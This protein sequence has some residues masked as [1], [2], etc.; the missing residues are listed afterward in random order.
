MENEFYDLFLNEVYFGKTEEIL[1]IENQLRVIRK[2]FIGTKFDASK[3]NEIIKLNRMIEDTFGF[4]IFSLNIELDPVPSASTLPV[5]YNFNVTMNKNNYSIEP[6][7]YKFK[8]E[9]DYRCIVTMS[10]G[11]IFN[12]YFTTEE[13]MACLLHELGM[14]FYSCMSEDNAI[15]TSI[16]TA[17]TIAN[18]ISNIVLDILDDREL[19]SY[20]ADMVGDF[21]FDKASKDLYKMHPDYIQKARMNPDFAR[22]IDNN[23]NKVA[24]G[25]A[26]ATYYGGLTADAMARVTKYI[27]DSPLYKRY[28]EGMQKNVLNHRP[29][30]KV[31][32]NFW[33]Y[34]AMVGKKLI[35]PAYDFVKN[36]ITHDFNYLAVVLGTVKEII[37]PMQAFMR[38]ATNPITYIALPVD[39][40]VLRAAEN[41]PTMYGYGAAQSS[42]LAKMKS[43]NSIK[44]VKHVL[45]KSDILKVFYNLITTPSKVLN[46]VF[47]PK[48]SDVTSALDQLNLLKKELSK[49]NLDPKMKESIEEDIMK[50]TISLNRLTDISKGVGDADIFRKLYNRFMYDMMRKTKNTDLYKST[51]GKWDDKRFA[52]YDANVDRVRGDI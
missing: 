23:L 33:S 19:A 35:N 34:A 51:K 6:N 5:G 20:F 49:D 44:F 21:A 10:T 32:Y 37:L 27:I 52:S 12:K 48:Q 50:L 39:Y 13:I 38:K 40:N 22:V 8:K 17:T 28:V 45:G 41:F 29:T 18:S 42:Y 24:A 15:L 31:V 26:G 9:Y 47:D 1:A 36:L 30:R 3:D 46:G 11:L 14:V 4:G 43:N 16:Y 7:T 25:A 2:K